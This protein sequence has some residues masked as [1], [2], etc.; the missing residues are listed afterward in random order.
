MTLGEEALT[1]F[2]E[3]GGVNAQSLLKKRWLEYWSFIARRYVQVNELVR[4][5]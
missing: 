2:A 4:I 1:R 5:T 3:A